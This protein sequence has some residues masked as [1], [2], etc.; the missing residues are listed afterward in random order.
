MFTFLGIAAGWALRGSVVAVITRSKISAWLVYYLFILVLSSCS[1]D[2]ASCT[3]ISIASICITFRDSSGGPVVPTR[4]SFQINSSSKRTIV[5]TKDV[6]VSQYGFEPSTSKDVIWCLN[7]GEVEGMY[8]IEAE[9]NK[10][11][12]TKA[13]FIKK[14]T[15]ACHID[16]TRL[17]FIFPLSTERP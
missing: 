12:I 13:V 14:K 4:I 1:P 10:Y 6:L 3:F 11:T 5:T 2:D 17:L 15:G 7:S 8:N 9:W 16:T